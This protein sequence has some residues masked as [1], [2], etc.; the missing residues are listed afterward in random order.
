MAQPSVPLLA[1]V[2]NAINAINTGSG[3]QDVPGRKNAASPR[4]KSVITAAD[5]QTAQAAVIAVLQT[6]PGGSESTATG[7]NH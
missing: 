1:P 7:K 5:G 4:W 2:L 3:H 6:R